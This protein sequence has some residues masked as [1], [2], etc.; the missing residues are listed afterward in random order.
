MIHE[1]AS[2][3]YRNNDLDSLYLFLR[4]Y[5][6]DLEDEKELA[7]YLESMVFHQGPTF[8]LRFLYTS[9]VTDLGEDG[10][11]RLHHVVFARE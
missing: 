7:W 9:R 5:A 10:Q 11:R 2:G 8:A 6:E 1:V 4:H 3:L